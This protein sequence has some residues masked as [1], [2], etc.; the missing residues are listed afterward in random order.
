M[1]T[2]RTTIYQTSF[3]SY[4]PALIDRWKDQKQSLPEYSIANWIFWAPTLYILLPIGTLD[5]AQRD[6][7]LPITAVIQHLQSPWPDPPFPASN[8]A[9]C[10]VQRHRA[11]KPQM[12]GPI[13][14]PQAAN[15][16]VFE[17]G[18]RKMST[19]IS[20]FAKVRCNYIK[21]VRNVS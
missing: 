6:P 14:T 15:S 12:P 18:T 17:S 11:A 1:S 21:M 5:P 10:S 16:T 4:F 9:Q 3:T 2:N 13:D 20:S 8:S 7:H 19:M